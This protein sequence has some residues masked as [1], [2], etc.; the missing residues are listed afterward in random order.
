MPKKEYLVHLSG[1]FGYDV[2]VEAENEEEAEELAE[3]ELET[4]DPRDFSFDCA[5]VEVFEQKN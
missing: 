1:C 3:T 4:A 2:Y 5:N